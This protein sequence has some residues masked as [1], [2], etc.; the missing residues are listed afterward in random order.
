MRWARLQWPAL[1]AALTPVHTFDIGYLPSR[2]H[3]ASFSR[4][5][6]L[7][8]GPEKAFSKISPPTGQE[9]RD[10]RLGRGALSF[11]EDGL[12]A[13][14]KYGAAGLVSLVV[15][16]VIFWLVFILPAS[17][18]IFHQS[19][20]AWVPELDDADAIAAFWSGAGGVWLF[21]KIPPIEA[22][23]WAWVFAMTPWVQKNVPGL[24]AM[25]CPDAEGEGVDLQP[26]PNSMPPALDL[27]HDTGVGKRQRES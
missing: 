2:V 13:A 25:S 24:A 11:L 26:V 7:F 8:L 12:D 19:S 1:V 20:G 5:T 18:F 27:V 6:H 14:R 21:C 4:H 15:E 3:I 22:A 23:R 9:S 16:T 10:K 17:A